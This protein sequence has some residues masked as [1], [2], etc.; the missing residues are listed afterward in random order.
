MATKVVMEALSPTMEEGRL[1]EWKKQEGE[2]VKQG[3]VLAEV[4]TDKA[5]MDLVARADGTMLKHVIA[6]GATVPVGDLVAVIGA[7]GE[8]VSA[9][10]GG[11]AEP[12]KAEPAKAPKADQQA[13]QPTA[14]TSNE[15]TSMPPAP[16]ARAATESAGAPAAQPPREPQPQPQGGDG[17]RV[18]ASPLARKIAAERGLDLSGVQGSGPAGRIVQRDLDNIQARPAAAAT[19][20]APAPS[21]VPAFTPQF[22]GEPFKDVPLSQMRKTIAKRLEPGSCSEF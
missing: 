3:E 16:P 7:E 18:K 21:P 4:E 13:V 6:A 9:L 17:G 8:D 10:A 14:G 15:P 12:A 20:K 2:A 1:V 19:A 5:V 22:A 11:K